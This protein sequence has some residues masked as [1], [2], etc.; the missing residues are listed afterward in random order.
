MSNNTRKIDYDGVLDRWSRGMS[1]EEIAVDLKMEANSVN[2]IVARGRVAGDAR[3]V[4]RGK[5]HR[6][7]GRLADRANAGASIIALRRKQ[8]LAKR[9]PID[10]ASLAAVV[11]AAQVEIVR[12]PLGAHIGW[13]PSWFKSI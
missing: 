9:F 11:A 8:R 4:W 7:F 3:A 5:G 2:V 12:L 10:K 13:R 1:D 6:K